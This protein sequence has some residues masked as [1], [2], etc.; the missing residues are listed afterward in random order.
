MPERP[1]VIMEDVF[2]EGPVL[3][4]FRKLLEQVD[5]VSPTNST[6]QEIE[7]ARKKAIVCVS[8]IT[9]VTR[10]KLASMPALRI[11]SAWGVGYNHIDVDTA[12]AMG[13]PVCINPTF[14][15]SVAEAAMTLILA[16]SKRLMYLVRYA[17]AGKRP[18][19]SERGME[20]RGKRLGVIG[21]GRIGREIG[22]LGHR[23]D[24]EIVAYD[25]F[26]ECDQ[27][28]GW[29][30]PISL[31]ELLSVSDYVVISAPLTPKTYHM[32]GEKQ[33]ELMKPSAYLVN[34]ARGPLVDEAALLTSLRNRRIA[35]AGLDVFEEEPVRADNPLLALDN[36]IATPHKL[37][38]TH[39]SLQQVCE[40]I[41]ENILRVISG[42]NPLYVV[43]PETLGG[44]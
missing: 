17:R 7:D 42:Q 9:P 30:R 39:E 43:N 32:I 24:M 28:H 18:S 40:S 44:K 33:L 27:V 36:V 8:R 35:G 14:S 13:I 26:L 22:D 15:R 38:A 1:V 16:L 25:P 5:V 20:I 11:V 10:E 19:E 37:A 4:Y 6:H 2:L 29:C 12:T 31:N 21:Y 41:E 3:E 23:L 34:I